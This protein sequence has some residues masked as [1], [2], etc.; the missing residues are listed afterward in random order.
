LTTQ[1]DLS[2]LAIDRPASSPLRKRERRHWLSRYVLPG[3]LLVGFLALFA[4]AARD[5]FMTAKEVTIVPVLTMRS[6]VSAEGTPLFKAAGWVE[7]RPTAV[8]ATALTEGF[9]KELLV[10]EGQTVA[11]GDVIA[12]LVDDDARLAL[13]QAEATVAL[14]TAEVDRAQATLTAAKTNVDY[15][16][17]LQAD[18]AEAEGMLAQAERELANLPFKVK[19]AAA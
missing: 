2:R 3:G 1:V 16:L 8:Q 9:V 11:A 15:P 7:P 6:A 13:E 14:R 10:I 5:R 4:W 17:I 18:L 19:A 12:R